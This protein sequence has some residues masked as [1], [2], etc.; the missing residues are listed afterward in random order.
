M[1]PSSSYQPIIKREEIFIVTPDGRT[2]K[3]LYLNTIDTTVKLELLTCCALQ[4]ILPQQISS[5]SQ[6]FVYNADGTELANMCQTRP[7]PSPTTSLGLQQ[8][9][10]EET[11]DRFCM[12][13]IISGDSSALSND[14]TADVIFN[15]G[16]TSTIVRIAH[17][18]Y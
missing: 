17:H 3:R 14:K 16:F 8:V 9:A 4:E 12:A 7:T 2:I 10:G 15:L 18:H 1:L 11:N 6:L 5:S 13:G